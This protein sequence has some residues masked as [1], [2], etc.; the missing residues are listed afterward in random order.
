MAIES[1]REK[2]VIGEQHPT[3]LAKLAS[4]CTEMA[5]SKAVVN[6]VRTARPVVHRRA[7]ARPQPPTQRN[8]SGARQDVS[9]QSAACEV[10]GLGGSPAT[11]ESLRDVWRL[12]SCPQRHWP[13]EGRCGA[14]CCGRAAA[15]GGRRPPGAPATRMWTASVVAASAA[16][17]DTGLVGSGSMPETTIGTMQGEVTA[18]PDDPV[19]AER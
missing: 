2:K 9:R 19:H 1:K 16:A 12:V 13:G 5:G 6:W 10:S 18:E 7:A 11:S 14:R 17:T 4:V 15:S 8:H 3:K